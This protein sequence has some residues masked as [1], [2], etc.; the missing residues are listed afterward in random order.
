MERQRGQSGWTDGKAARPR[1]RYVTLARHRWQYYILSFPK[2]KAQTTHLKQHEFKHGQSKGKDVDRKGKPI[3]V[4]RM[5][6]LR[7]AP[8]IKAVAAAGERRE[9]VVVVIVDVV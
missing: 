6:P 1:T 7:G 3:G 2:L 4:V 8:R 9:C 5:R